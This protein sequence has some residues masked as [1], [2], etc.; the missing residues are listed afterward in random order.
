MVKLRFNFSE[1][2]SGETALEEMQTIDGNEN[3]VSNRPQSGSVGYRGF[4]LSEAPSRATSTLDGTYKFFDPSVGYPG[5]VSYTRSEANGDVD[6]NGI[7]GDIHLLNP[8]KTLIRIVFD[9]P[10]DEY[11]T[12]FYFN[13]VF[14]TN[15]SP[16]AYLVVDA[17]EGRFTLEVAKWNKPYKNL[18]VADISAV[19]EIEVS[20]KLKTL[21]YSHNSTSSTNKIFI[22]ILEQYLD[23]SFYDEYRLFE[24]LYSLG[25][26]TEGI[27]VQV[28]DDGEFDGEYISSEWNFKTQD[29]SV[30]LSCGDPTR[31]LKTNQ[32]GNWPVEDRTLRQVCDRLAQ[33]VPFFNYELRNLETIA[34][35]TLT[36]HFKPIESVEKTLMDICKSYACRVYWHKDVFILEAA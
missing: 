7:Q 36:N 20:S 27:S 35:V 14:Y 18:K 6:Y 24:T 32:L 19:S 12:E 4:F 29:H 13:D 26:L 15:D 1:V 5:S 8:G 17:Y 30:S 16:V 2:L 10:S 23:A 25:Y 11:A 34:D 22:G 28:Y 33:E 3:N 21:S 9:V 31:S